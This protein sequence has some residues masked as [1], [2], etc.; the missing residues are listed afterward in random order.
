MKKLLLLT[1]LLA[2]L[3]PI[4]AQASVITTYSSPILALSFSDLNP[5]NW[6]KSAAEYIGDVGTAAT[7]TLKGKIDV[8]AKI[9]NVDEL[10]NLV[11]YTAAQLGVL[12]SHVGG[13][14][15]ETVDFSL[16]QME[17]FATVLDS[18]AGKRIDNLDEKVRNQLRD[19]ERITKGIS[20]DAE[21]IIRVISQ[22][23]E[24][25]INTSGDR[26]ESALRVG[27]NELRSTINT[28][29][30]RVESALRVSGNE[31]RASITTAS[32]ELDQL[33][34]LSGKQ[35]IKITREAGDQGVR[36]IQEAGDQSVRLTR[37][38]GTEF[39]AVIEKTG[40][41]TRLTIKEAIAQ[42]GQEARSTI[43]D[44]IVQSGQETR[45]TMKVAGSE[46][47]IVTEK[48]SEES[49]QVIE[50]ATKNLEGIIQEVSN[51]LQTL[52]DAAETSSLRI[53]EGVLYVVD[54]TA[55]LALIVVSTGSGL[56]FL[57][58]ASYGWGKAVLRFKLPKQYV[59]RGI[60]FSFM[61]MTFV[62][63]F[64]PFVFLIPEVRAQVLLP[65]SLA[66]PYATQ[67]IRIGTR[68]PV[69]PKFRRSEPGEVV[70]VGTNSNATPFLLVYGTNLDRGT[71]S[72]KFGNIELAIPGQQGD[73]LRI[74]LSPVYAN[75]EL[76]DHISVTIKT[77]SVR[78]PLI[79]IP[80][81]NRLST[82]S[83]PT[84]TA[85][86]APQEP[87]SP[88][89]T[90]QD[91]E[92]LITRWLQAKQKIFAS[93]FDKQSVSEMTTGDLYSEI[94]NPDGRVDWLR[95][96]N[97][98]YQFSSQA[99]KQVENLDYQNNRITVVVIVSESRTL[100]VN[101]KI[102]PKNTGMDTRRVRYVLE[103]I[104]GV[105]KISNYT[106]LDVLSREDAR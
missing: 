71:P 63:A 34:E 67:G 64:A 17:K 72:A 78:D 49:Q 93:P 43:R 5:L 58:I 83:S 84:S 81:I 54:R 12:T 44:S 62:S 24:K 95:K 35:A 94:A 77:D 105:W 69:L 100:Y 2:Y 16:G 48:I 101:G 40:T 25:L 82:Q 88:P 14:T 36:F 98:Y 45:S 26:V 15:R 86:P 41:E 60:V 106:T 21:R 31:L 65:F 4:P 9:E 46:A 32:D 50:T 56:I 80:V 23:T 1:V 47:V 75:P 51:D 89:I 87:A 74:D 42:S 91:V 8:N 73:L 97:A 79:S 85:L 28:G 61:G 90:R 96:N 22:E 20:A 99:V 19:I 6:V 102:N 39:R 13:E 70:V 92:N 53:I 68:L 103:Q 3:S 104:N 29:G 76:A 37:T 11:G 30:D 66:K 55:D 38:T 57:F 18:V 27:S 52:I 7:P 33:V 59:T 10:Q